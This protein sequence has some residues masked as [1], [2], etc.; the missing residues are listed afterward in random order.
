MR[1]T[2]PIEQMM[3]FVFLSNFFILARLQN[4]FKFGKIKTF[5]IIKEIITMNLLMKSETISMIPITK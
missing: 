5:S 2:Q 3:T 4:S 1:L